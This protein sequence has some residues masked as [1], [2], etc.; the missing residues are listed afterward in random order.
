LVAEE[1]QAKQERWLT[2][3]R[4]KAYIKMY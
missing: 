2:S 1:A 4:Q 3:L